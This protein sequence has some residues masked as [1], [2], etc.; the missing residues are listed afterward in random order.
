MKNSLLPKKKLISASVNSLDLK[1]NVTAT[2][3]HKLIQKHDHA[4]HI[5]P[6]FESTTKAIN[7][8]S[9]LATLVH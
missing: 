9:T 8:I 4:P 1:S 5:T 3:L 7:L 6:K 2:N